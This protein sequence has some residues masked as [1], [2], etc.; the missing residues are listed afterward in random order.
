M[1]EKKVYLEKHEDWFRRLM[2]REPRGY[3]SACVNLLLP[4]TRPEADLGFVIM[5]QPTVYP[6]MSG[7]NTMC[8]VTAVLETGLI[9]MQEPV[10]HLVLDTPAGLVPVDAMCQGGR[11][12]EVILENVPAF[13][14][15]IDTPIEVRGLGRILVDVAWG[16]MF[17]VCADVRQ[18]G[19]EIDKDNGRELMRLG[20]QIKTAAREQLSV[21]HPENPDINLIENGMLY[22]PPRYAGNDARNT[23][24][25]TTGEF[26]WDRPATWSAVLD[27]CPCGTG[28][29]ARMA[30]LAAQGR[31]GLGQKFRNEGILD[32]VFTGELVRRTKV[33]EY[34]AVIPRVS[35]RAWITGYA[36]YVLADDDPFPEGYTLGDIWAPSALSQA[37]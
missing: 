23:V 35:G 13:A 6:A 7:S 27:R 30:V 5:E 21:S 18:L 28:T 29:C 25:I 3:P 1:Y 8:V 14:T 36:Q 32:T 26:D 19:I 17:Y 10:T 4:A 2:L 20:E 31:L 16:G 34:E 24:I 22:G 33:G 37:S 15:H 12:I 9:K 11:V